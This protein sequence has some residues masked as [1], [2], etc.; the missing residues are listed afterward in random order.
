MTESPRP[1][2]GLFVV[3]EGG[4]GAGKTTQAELLTGWLEEAGHEVVRTFEPGDSVVGRQIRGLL[5]DP[6]WGDIDPR[7][8]ALLY[9]ADKAQHLFA[10]VRP[11]LARGAV[12][13][14]DRYLDSMLAYQGAGRVLERSEVAEIAR[15]ATDGLRADLTVLLDVDPHAS[16]HTK[17]DKDRLEGAGIDFHDRV[18][19][20]FLELAGQDPQRYLVLPARDDRH[21]IAAAIRERVTALL[22]PDGAD[23][24]GRSPAQ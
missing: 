22:G 5:L 6:V 14:C 21:R 23:D 24:C 12:V 11:A 7:A 8:E 3:L 17:V 20:E 18:R 19:Q 4:D 13:V 2:R 15:W 1:D 10:V 16:V 9:A